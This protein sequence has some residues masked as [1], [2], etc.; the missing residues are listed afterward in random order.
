MA[1]RAKG[2]PFGCQGEGDFATR[3]DADILSIPRGLPDLIVL[4]YDWSASQA[5]LQVSVNRS[6]TLLPR[7][8]ISINFG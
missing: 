1:S 3:R 6:V 5:G 7:L 2:G 4:R 8:L